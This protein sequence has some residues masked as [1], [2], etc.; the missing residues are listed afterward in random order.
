MSVVIATLGGE[1]LSWTIDHLNRG[2]K[3]PA[4]ILVCIPEAESARVEHL[5]QQNVKIIKVPFR[6]QVAQRAYGLRRVSKPLV[7]QLDDDIELRPEDLGVLVGTL[8]ELGRGHALAPLYCHLS[9]GLYITQ[10]SRG[11]R[12][13][14]QS[15]NA[16]LICG[17]PWGIRR[18]GIISPAGIGYG[19]DKAYC[20]S[21][22]FE[23][24]WVPGG[25]VLCHQEDLVT[26]EYYPFVGKAYTEDLVHSA[27]WRKKGVRLWVIPDASCLTADATMPFS[28]RAMKDVIK[29]HGY[30]LK[31][32]GGQAWRLKLWNIL[33][34]SKQMML[35]AFKHI[36]P[37]NRRS[38]K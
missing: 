17:A 15:L 32:V 8:A 12:G 11:V 7:L 34:I 16:F 4:E 31:L 10:Y 2:E 6:G 27:L 37:N 21:A 36:S 26:E 29:A 5:S 3:I 33:H 1:T 30:V 19:V 23:S 13:L 9:T 18:M 38:G 22:P 35:V 28:W 14:L 25:C 24:Q 20:K